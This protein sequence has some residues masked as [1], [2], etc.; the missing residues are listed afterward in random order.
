MTHAIRL[1]LAVV[2]TFAT[3]WPAM[4]ADAQSDGEPITVGPNDW[5]WWRGPMSNGHAAPNQKPPRQW[6]ASKN[7]LWKVDLP[8]RGHASPT[9][10]GDDVY[11]PTADH[12]TNQQLVICY[13]R[14][15]GKEKWRTVVHDGG[16]MSGNKKASQASCTI[17]CDGKRLYVNFVNGGAAH[18]TAL[19]RSGKKLWQKRLTK[20]TIHQGYGSSPAFYRSLVIVSA[21]NKAGGVIAALDRKSGDVVWKIDRPKKPNYA[22]PRIVRAAGRDQLV[23][24]G[25]DLVTSLDPM[26]GK[27]IWEIA[28]ATTECVTTTVTDGTHVYS[29]GGYPKNHVAAIKADGSGKI[30]WR[31]GTRVYVPSMFVKDGYLYAVADAGQAVCWKSDTGKEMWSERL[32]GSFSAS[33]VLVGDHVYAVNEKGT[34]Y[35]YK[36]SPQAFD[37]IAE[38]QLGNEALSTPAIC[39]GRIYMRVAERRNGKR[40]ESLYCIGT[41]GE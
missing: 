37:L 24:T 13:D 28:G 36:I 16:L 7:I 19:D 12:G 27:T 38:N 39:G 25:C 3:L 11:L 8:G 14:A 6:S 41:T 40:Q 21:D 5:P 17:A 2:L 23:F 15:T 4:P 29:S 35:V 32:R 30:A 33:P 20:Y 10:V 1:F 9:V 22:S 18:T 26:T 31:N 34:T